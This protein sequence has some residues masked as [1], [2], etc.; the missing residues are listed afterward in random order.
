MLCVQHVLELRSFVDSNDEGPIRVGVACSFS[1]QL[2]TVTSSDQLPSQLHYQVPL[3][4]PHFIYHTSSHQVCHSS[5][6]E[7]NEN[8]E[9]VLDVPPPND[10][11]TTEV[12]VVPHTTGLHPLPTLTLFCEG[13]RVSGSQLLNTSKG[14]LVTISAY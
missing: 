5:E 2:K 12:K 11:L 3:P 4:T 1:F 14:Q 10:T 13:V 9:G 8:C 7:F 6:W